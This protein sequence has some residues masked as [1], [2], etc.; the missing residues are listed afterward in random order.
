MG[1]LW[2]CSLSYMCVRLLA[3]LT[4]IAGLLECVL[5]H[6]LHEF[7]SAIHVLTSSQDLGGA[8][9]R[10][11]VFELETMA[12]FVVPRMRVKTP[13]PQHGVASAL[14]GAVG[15]SRVTDTFL[16]FLFFY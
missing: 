2:A 15:A 3:G 5:S 14:F 12:G 4:C 11:S 10:V 9:T 16:S 1:C 6:W 13:K 8:L 7:M